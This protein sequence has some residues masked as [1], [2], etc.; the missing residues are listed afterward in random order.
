VWYSQTSDK[1][2]CDF[3][4]WEARSMKCVLRKH[5]FSENSGI[6]TQ[7]LRSL[8]MI[9][10]WKTVEH[11]LAFLFATIFCIWMVMVNNLKVSVSEAMDTQL[12]VQPPDVAHLTRFIVTLL[13]DTVQTFSSWPC[14][15]SGG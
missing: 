8:E 4:I 12:L 1:T 15:G 13:N 9:S 10:Q 11:F 3:Y 2:P 6:E 14:H 5:L 7:K